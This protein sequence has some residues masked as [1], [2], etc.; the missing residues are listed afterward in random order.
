[1]EL[2]T[3]LES[4]D[5]E[6]KA[7]GFGRFIQA[8]SYLSTLWGLGLSTG[9]HESVEVESNFL[10]W[11]ET[12]LGEYA[13]AFHTVGDFEKRHQTWS[14]PAQGLRCVV[15]A[16]ALMR[17]V[18][19]VGKAHFPKLFEPGSIDDICLYSMDGTL[20]L[21]E[22][23]AQTINGLPHADHL[24]ALL[25]WVYS[26]PSARTMWS[27]VAVNSTSG[28]LGMTLPQAA[29]RLSLSGKQYGQNFYATKV[30]LLSITAHEQPYEF[31]ASL[32]PDILENAN[33]P[34][35]KRRR[36]R[37]EPGSAMSNDEWE[38]IRMILKCELEDSRSRSTF[39]ILLAEALE[40]T[41]RTAG[42]TESLTT[43]HV[44]YRYQTWTRSKRLEA[45]MSALSHLRSKKPQE[46]AAKVS[47]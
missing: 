6:L 3:G 15:P 27:S 42:Y 31:A 9:H 18:F 12:D 46:E 22:R 40:N 47:E 44:S 10:H 28:V 35:V 41:P 17:A 7:V 1:M 5:G 37:Q 36:E 24:T 33:P 14:F 4:V 39:N 11:R 23:L 43:H 21:E 2:V 34:L 26:F 30:T 29:V 25:R 45:A 13:G 8:G 20:I 32:S 16:L 19:A 38:S